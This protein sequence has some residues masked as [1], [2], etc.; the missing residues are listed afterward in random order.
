V[1]PANGR[2]VKIISTTDEE[3]LADDLLE[4]DADLAGVDPADLASLVDALHD[5]L[6]KI[7][8]KLTVLVEHRT[9]KDWYTTKEVADIVEKAEF[10]V[11]QWCR[12]GRVNAEKRMSG[13]GAFQDW[14]ISHAELQRYQK[15]GLIPVR[16]SS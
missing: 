4:E 7:E 14:V 9:V 15:E 12:L 2:D 13:R 11:R 10:T 6:E 16:R 8:S 1:G 3:T 5:R